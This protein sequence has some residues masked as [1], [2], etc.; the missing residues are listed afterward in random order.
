VFSIP[1]AKKSLTPLRFFATLPVMDFYFI[2]ISFTA[3]VFIAA[4]SPGPDFVIAVRNAVLHSQRAGI[5]TAIGIGLG[6]CAHLTYS[7]LGIAA[8]I[9]KSVFLFT[10]IKYAGA[11]YLIYIGYKALRSKGY[12][13]E[14]IVGKHEDQSDISVFKALWQ[15]FLTNLLNPKATLFFLSLLPQ[16]MGPETLITQKIILGAT[17][18]LIPTLWFIGVSI[19]LNQRTIRRAFMRSAKWIDR[20]CGGLLMALGVRLALSKMH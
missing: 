11:A 19:V 15:G 9:A 20:V 17:A 10:L 7:M 4:A 8:V 2:W 3:I 6:I 16:F 13:N 12:D 5:F 18:T 1:E 14:T